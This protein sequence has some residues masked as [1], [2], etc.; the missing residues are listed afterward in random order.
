MGLADERSSLFFEY[1]RL[2]ELVQPTWIVMEQV[3]SLLT[4]PLDYK[5]V[6]TEME[7]LGYAVASVVVNSL[8]YVPQT[9]ERLIIVGHRQHR[10]AA[11]ALL[12]LTKDG[13]C[14]PDQGK[15][16]RRRP[17]LEP[18]SGPGAYRKSRRPTHNQDSETWV[19]TDYANTLT[20]SDVGTSRATVIVVDAL[21]YPRVLTPEEWELAHGFPPGWTSAAGSD[22]ARWHALG[23][24]VSPPIAARV[25]EGI[26]IQ[27]RLAK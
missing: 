19:A 14:H 24:A 15:P 7:N 2:V 18:T 20:V 4:I 13:A 12:P 27:E 26:L 16:T 3:L 17:A 23:N 21:G 9:R 25:A 10:A 8:A 1:M 5:T 6:L 22:S 11:G